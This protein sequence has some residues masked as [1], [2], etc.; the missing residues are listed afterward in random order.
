ME[1]IRTPIAEI[2]FNKEESIL[3]IKLIEGAEMSLEN[4]KAHY[5]KINALV[6]GAQYLA[7]VDASNYYTIERNAWAYASQ[8]EVYSNRRAVA[9][10]NS[11]TANKL[12][13]SFFKT[14]YDAAM[15]MQIFD[16]RKEALKWLKSFSLE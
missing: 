3:F 5:E 6:G 15:P 4:A 11:S 2:S 12:T 14:A 13:T 9:H 1:I 7:L 8:K 10:F 16:T